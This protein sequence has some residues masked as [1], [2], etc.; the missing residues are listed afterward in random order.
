RLVALAVLLEDGERQLGERFQAEVV[1]AVVQE[2]VDSSGSVA[3]EALPAADPDGHRRGPVR[4]TRAGAGRPRA[5]PARAGPRPAGGGP[6][7]R[8]RRR[9]AS[10]SADPRRSSTAAARSRAGRSR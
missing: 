7:G 2:A 5:G 1:D 9:V 8:T 3:V 6:P 4:R 10:R